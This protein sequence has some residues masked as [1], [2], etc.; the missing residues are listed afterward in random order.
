M[1][2]LYCWLFQLLLKE[3]NRVRSK[4]PTA[5]EVLMDPHLQILN[6]ILRPGL[7]SY[8]WS[9]LKISEY[10]E[11]VYE[12]LA[13]LELLIDRANQLTGKCEHT[14]DWLIAASNLKLLA[15]IMVVKMVCLSMVKYLM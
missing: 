10:V 8:T 2:S 1:C 11:A 12:G 14:A 4:I 3:N 7:S 15:A 5:F 6:E 9:S 13:N